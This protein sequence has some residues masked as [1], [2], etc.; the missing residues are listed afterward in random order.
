MPWA[1]QH[2]VSLGERQSFNAMN[3]LLVMSKA[4]ICVSETNGVE[5]RGIDNRDG[6]G[7]EAVYTRMK[8][9]VNR[10]I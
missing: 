2:V 9:D 10:F 4:A 5:R 8:E 6:M 7:G 3:S 1:I